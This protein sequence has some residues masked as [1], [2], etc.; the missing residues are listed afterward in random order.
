MRHIQFMDVT[1]LQYSVAKCCSSLRILFK[2]SH[3]LNP[4]ESC[5][6]YDAAFAIADC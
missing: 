5:A 6:S 3:R 2:T 1:R 4:A